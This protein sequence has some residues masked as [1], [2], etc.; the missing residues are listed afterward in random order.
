MPT[1]SAWWLSFN[2]A[3]KKNTLTIIVKPILS[4]VFKQK[5]KNTS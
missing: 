5:G 1:V 4:L 2:F 3:E